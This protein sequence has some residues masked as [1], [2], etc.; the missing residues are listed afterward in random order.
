M[1]NLMN[2]T[3]HNILT[4]SCCCCCAIDVDCSDKLK[5]VVIQWL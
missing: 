4:A 1:S 5:S 3:D 2:I